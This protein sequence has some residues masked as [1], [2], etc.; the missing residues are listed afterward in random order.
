MC[1]SV[2]PYTTRVMSFLVF[3]TFRPSVHVSLIFIFLSNHQVTKDDVIVAEKVAG[4]IGT[5]LDI[6]DVLLVGTRDGTVVGRPTVPGATVK[7]FV[8]E[9]TKDKKVGAPA[10]V[11][12]GRC[13][14]DFC[15]VVFVS[16]FQGRQTRRRH[17][18]GG[19]TRVRTRPLARPRMFFVCVWKILYFRLYI[20][21]WRG[22]LVSSSSTSTWSRNS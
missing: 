19:N 22:A 1:R 6:S 8:E 17:K 4:D 7:L 9:Q 18:K 13:G 21:I 15:G 2:P 20:Y 10:H 16:I 5:T 12:L 14:L 11:C 3:L